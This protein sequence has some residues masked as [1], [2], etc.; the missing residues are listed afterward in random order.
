MK[1]WIDVDNPPQVQYLAPFRRAFEQRGAEVV[2]TARD[3]GNTFEL[4]RARDADFIPVG[5]SFGSSKLRKA[6]GSL[7]RAAALMRHV[8]RPNA[9]LCASRSSA[10]AART[11]GVPSFVV[12]DYEHANVGVYT[13]TGSVFLHPESIASSA[14]TDRGMRADRLRSFRGLKE[15][16]SFAGV[17]LDAEPAYD[18]GGNGAVRV[19][20]RPPAEES[21]YYNG[22]SRP[23]ALALLEHLAR[24][25]A[26]IVFSPRYPWQAEYVRGLPWRI[27]PT[28]LRVAVP[29]VSLLKGVDAVVSSGGTMLREAAYLGRPAYSIL[30]S[31]IGGVDRHLERIGRVVF[32]SGPEEFDRIRLVRAGGLAPLAENPELLDELADTVVA[33]AR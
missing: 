4:L 14:F 8:G 22:A 7:E 28:V 16:V 27:E 1:V 6:T 26:K 9:L 13:K 3:Y 2:V 24:A 25:G 5:R 32:V 33:G 31:R 18:P 29:F 17:D 21:H 23:L 19:L 10:I 11:L 30:Q 20:F 12:A 15:D